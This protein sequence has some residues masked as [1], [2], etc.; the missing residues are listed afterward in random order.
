MTGNVLPFHTSQANF[1]DEEIHICNTIINEIQDYQAQ[2]FPVKCINYFCYF[3]IGIINSNKLYLYLYKNE[4]D[5]CNNELIDSFEIDNIGSENF[6]CQLMQS[7]SNGEVLTCFYEYQ[8]SYEIVANNLDINLESENIKIESLSIQ[9]R[10]NNKAKI[11]KTVLSKDGT[12][13]YVC[14]IN[15]VNS[16]E[17]LIYSISDNKWGNFATYL[18]LCLSKSSYLIFNYYDIYDE[19]FLYCYQSPSKIAVVKLNDNLEIM[20]LMI[21]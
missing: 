11:I 17:C 14:Y 6:S 19:Y 12:K 4:K 3:V 2:V 5:T 15:Q 7:P 16:C 18:T 20:I 10:Y 21:Q 1:N 13:S 9:S 8:N